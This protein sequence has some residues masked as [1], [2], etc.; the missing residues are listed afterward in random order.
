VASVAIAPGVLLVNDDT[1][2]ALAH[3]LIS[4]LK[5]PADVAMLLVTPMFLLVPIIEIVLLVLL[6]KKAHAMKNLG[7]IECGAPRSYINLRKRKRCIAC[8]SQLHRT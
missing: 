1:M 2:M 4:G 6:M 5:I 8:G 3:Q 7:C